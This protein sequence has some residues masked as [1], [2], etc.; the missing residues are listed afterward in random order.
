[1]NIFSFDQSKNSQKFVFHPQPTSDWTYPRS[2]QKILYI[3]GWRKSVPPLHC[4]YLLYDFPRQPTRIR[5]RFVS[6]RVSR[7][8]STDTL[9]SATTLFSFSATP[10]FHHNSQFSS[11][12]NCY[13]SLLSLLFASLSSTNSSATTS[14]NQLRE[15][16]RGHDLDLSLRRIRSTRYPFAA[17]FRIV[18]P[19]CIGQQN[20]A[21]QWPATLSQFSGRCVFVSKP[22]NRLN[23]VTN[24]DKQ[25]IWLGW[26][27]VSFVLFDSEKLTNSRIGSVVYLCISLYAMAQRNCLSIYRYTTT[28][29]R[30][31]DTQRRNTGS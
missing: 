3:R 13:Y 15:A 24:D 28:V 18:S 11:R 4:Y 16:F 29:T 22:R 10:R 27:I 1:M 25:W 30:H 9:H 19:L 31:A 26:I 20:D 21:A 6:S 12:S 8:L 14:M 23:I 2:F 7:Y 5:S 17:Y